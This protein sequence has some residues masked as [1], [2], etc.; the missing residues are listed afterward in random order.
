MPT[1][2]AERVWAGTVPVRFVEAYLQSTL[3]HPLHQ[4]IYLRHVF[5]EGRA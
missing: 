4:G 3:E 1:C 2:G 5:A